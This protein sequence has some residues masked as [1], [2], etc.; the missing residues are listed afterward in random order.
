MSESNVRWLVLNGGLILM[1]GLVT[2]MLY[3]QVVIAELG[4][5]SSAVPGDIRGWKMAHMEC[6]LNGCL[7]IAI[8]A[9][10]KQMVLSPRVSFVIVWGL[11]VCGWTNAIAS[12]LAAWTGG[13]GAFYTG[14]DWNSLVHVLFF[15]GV[16]GV[17]AAVVALVIGAYRYRP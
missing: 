11:W 10:C 2:G 5:Q 9:A 4:G 8:A 15:L 3:G 7:I 1:L 13:R 14:L 12:S 16:L 6:L 17:I